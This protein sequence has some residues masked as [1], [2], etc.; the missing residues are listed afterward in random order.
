MFQNNSYQPFII[1]SLYTSGQKKYYLYKCI[2]NIILYFFINFVNQQIRYS[3][4]TFQ[5]V[6]LWKS[7]LCL[8]GFSK[9]FRAYYTQQNYLLYWL[10]KVIRK[11]HKNQQNTTAFIRFERMCLGYMYA[12]GSHRVQSNYKCYCLLMF[13]IVLVFWSS[14]VVLQY[15]VLSF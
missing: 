14:R 11:L 13:D 6:M 5:S 4:F 8:D 9:L 7:K 3:F 12:P 2:F 10:S 15:V 1:Q